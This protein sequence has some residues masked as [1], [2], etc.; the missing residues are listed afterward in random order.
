MTK[1]TLHLHTIRQSSPLSRQKITWTWHFRVKTVVGF[2]RS[3]I[4]PF[5]IDP[6]WNKKTWSE[7]VG[8]NKKTEPLSSY[9]RIFAPYVSLQSAAGFCIPQRLQQQAYA[10]SCTC[11]LAEWLLSSV[12]TIEMIHTTHTR[13][14][15]LPSDNHMMIS[16]FASFL[17][18][19]SHHANWTGLNSRVLNTCKPTERSQLAINWSSRIPT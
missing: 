15:A 1:N 8:R 6:V 2:H 18:P 5:R 17:K 9:T 14:S 19:R 4:R 16:L 11:A 12:T 13:R 10:R 7:S 3:D